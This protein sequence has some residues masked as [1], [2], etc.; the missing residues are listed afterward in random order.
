MAQQNLLKKKPATKKKSIPKRPKTGLKAIPLDRDFRYCRAFFQEEVDQKDIIKLCKDYVRKAFSKSEAQAILANPEYHFSM[1]SGRAAS[2][3][4]ENHGLTFEEPFQEYPERVYQAY[5]ELIEPGQAILDSRKKD[6]DAKA[7]RKVVSPQEL[8]RR[9]VNSTVGY[10]LDYLEDEWIEGKTTDID[11][12]TQFQKH[13]LK[14]ASAPYLKDRVEAMRAEYQGAYDKTDDQLVEAFSHLSRKEL[15]RRLEVCDTMSADLDKIQAA[16]KATRKKRTPKART[17]DKQ[18]K[19]FKYLKEDKT[20]YKLV[21][22]DPLSV[23][24]AFRLYTFNVK[25]RELTEYTTLAA[26]GFEIK[27]TTIQNFDPESSRKT[28]LRK[29]DAFLPI[30]LKKTVNQI[31]K[32]W[33]KL[34]TK[35]SVPTGR[36]NADT[37]LLRVE[38]K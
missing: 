11:L 26:N 3:F 35:T 2:I 10:D 30:V 31:G 19:Y 1:Y 29:P 15:K 16:S 9:K 27:G 25:N 36:I 34:T 33:D 13:E 21:S 7:Q 4:W 17:A 24:G 32:E 22:V 18:I 12:Y 38:H 8:M 5:A 6:E 37:I 23:P 14:G 28:R 20:N